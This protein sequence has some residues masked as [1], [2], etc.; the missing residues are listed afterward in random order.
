MNEHKL[1]Q[2]KGWRSKTTAEQQSQWN[3]FNFTN[4]YSYI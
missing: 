1:K 3:H 4:I 2:N